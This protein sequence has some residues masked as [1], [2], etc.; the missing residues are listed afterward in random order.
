M[1]RARLWTSE[2]LDEIVRLVALEKTDREIAAIMGLTKTSVDSARERYGITR[3]SR[4][5]PAP[6]DFAAKAPTMSINALSTLYGAAKRTIAK[7][8]EETGVNTRPEGSLVPAEFRALAGSKTRAEWAAHYNVSTGMIAR[9]C[10]LAKVEAKAY[11]PASRPVAP[12]SSQGTWQRPVNTTREGGTVGEAVFQL[13]RAGL[14]VYRLRIVKKTAPIDMW[15]VGARRLQEN[16][17]IKL[18]AERYGA[19]YAA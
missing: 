8:K 10:R 4:D 7:W 6:A 17:M 2:K 9:W 18:A 15:V 13:Q 19:R 16:D 1:P 12:G 11:V 3:R 14:S 5:R